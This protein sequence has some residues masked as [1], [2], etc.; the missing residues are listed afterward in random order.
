MLNK[1][2]KMIMATL[3][4]LTVPAVMVQGFMTGFL[5]SRNLYSFWFLFAFA[6][7]VLGFFAYIIVTDYAQVGAYVASFLAGYCILAAGFIPITL[8]FMTTEALEQVVEVVSGLAL[9]LVGAAT[10][11]SQGPTARAIAKLYVR[12][13][14]SNA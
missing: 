5:N 11:L 3:C 2:I 10:M 13:E 12:K 1:V 8:A 6:T 7:V 9:F 14:T 4:A